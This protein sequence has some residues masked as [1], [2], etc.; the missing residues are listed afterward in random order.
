MSP[1][2]TRE[3]RFR[4]YPTVSLALVAEVIGLASGPD[5]RLIERVRLG[6]GHPE[7]VQVG[8]LVEG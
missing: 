7:G 1:E 3:L 4:S 2:R 8:G 6:Q 5:L